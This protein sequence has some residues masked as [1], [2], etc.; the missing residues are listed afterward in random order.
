[1]FLI[2]PAHKQNQMGPKFAG[3][4]IRTDMVKG[5][6]GKKTNLDVFF[7][8]RSGKLRLFAKVF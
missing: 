6:R 2:L 5:Q 3:H 7:N 8:Y 1:M 4:A